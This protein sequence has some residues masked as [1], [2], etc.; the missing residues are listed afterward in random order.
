MLAIA[1]EVDA[2]D[3]KFRSSIALFELVPTSEDRV[4]DDVPEYPTLVSKPR[5]PSSKNGPFIPFSA[6]SG[7]A[8]ACPFGVKWFEDNGGCKENILYTIED[9]FYNKNR[10]LTIDT[11]TFP[12]VITSEMRIM[13]S[14]SILTDCL[15]G[16]IGDGVD[17][18]SIVNKDM[19]VNIDPEGIAVST[20]GGFW[21]VSEGKGTVGDKSKP[22]ETPNLLLKVT[23][24]A[25][26][27]ECTM[28]PKD[29][30]FL[31]QSRYGFEGV[32]E[33]GDR[34]IITI[35]REWG[36]ES[37]PRI[38]VYDTSAETWK[39]AF[40]PLDEPESQNDGWVGLADIAPVGGGKFL[41]LERDNQFGPDAAIKKI[42]AI[43]LGD[44]SFEDGKTVTKSLEKDLMG[45]LKKSNGQVFEKVEGLAVSKS[46]SIWFNNDNDG[47]DGNSGEQALLNVGTYSSPT[48]A[49]KKKQKKKSK[50][51]S[52]KIKPKKPKKETKK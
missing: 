14:D 42:Y 6:L 3:A 7:L 1:S 25:K 34:V 13:D 38:A 44:Y 32:A 5:D 35:Q 47:V 50:K 19:T 16:N 43:D 52:K 15:Q 27:T 36:D 39:Y 23:D 12:A 37:N 46:G 33:D 41:V 48:A 2:R 20:K 18:S 10:I 11:S 40:Y 21:I 26:I 8:S 45:D 29:G 31:D 4:D 22:F 9:S 51:D 30:S 17:V 24:D 28:L 49:P